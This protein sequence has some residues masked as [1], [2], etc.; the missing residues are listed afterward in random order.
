MK[1][2][3]Q[4]SSITSTATLQHHRQG[5]AQ[6]LVLT[7]SYNKALE[8]VAVEFRSRR[9]GAGTVLFR[10]RPARNM[11]G[12]DIASSGPGMGTEPGP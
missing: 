10:A 2:L 8:I 5:P 6:G 11:E 4:Q 9:L 12:G 7:A 1:R 3:S